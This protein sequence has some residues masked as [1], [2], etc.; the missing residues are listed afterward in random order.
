MDTYFIKDHS[1]IHIKY[2]EV[3]IIKMLEFFIDNINV[4]LSGHISQQIIGPKLRPF[5]C[6]FIFDSGYEAEF[7]QGHLKAGKEHLTQKFNFIYI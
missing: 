2:S 5:T 7:I 3:D 4:E 6:R 1:D